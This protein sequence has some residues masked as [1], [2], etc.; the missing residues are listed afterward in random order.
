MTSP[1]RRLSLDE[2]LDEFFFSADA[3]LLVCPITAQSR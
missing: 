3:N 1:N 2:V